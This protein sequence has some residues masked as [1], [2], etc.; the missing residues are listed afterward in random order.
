MASTSDDRCH[1][2]RLSPELLFN[3]CQLL[4]QPGTTYVDLVYSLNRAGHV[5]FRI[6]T[7]ADNFRYSAA[8]SRHSLAATCRLLRTVMQKQA[9][10]MGLCRDIDQPTKSL[11]GAPFANKNDLVCIRRRKQ[12][13][14]QWDIHSVFDMKRPLI[15]APGLIK[16]ARFFAVEYYRRRE[17]QWRPALETIGPSG[18]TVYKCVCDGAKA[19][20]SWFHSL[21]YTSLVNVM[22]LVRDDY[23]PGEYRVDWF[24]STVSHLRHSLD[25]GSG[26]FIIVPRKAWEP[27][28]VGNAAHTKCALR[29]RLASPRSDEL[30]AN[31]YQ[32]STRKS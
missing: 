7:C 27:Y 24:C 13:W 4:L 2:L 22:P 30:P 31:A 17:L 12:R 11:L 10:I 1:I 3:I 14:D 5:K 26:F 29:S 28:A 15:T 8:W 18:R 16:G 19:P 21:P 20:A 25:L 23:R 32:K 6:A 9:A